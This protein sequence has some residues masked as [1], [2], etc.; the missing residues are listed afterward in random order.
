MKEIAPPLEA[1]SDP[2]NASPDVP[3]GGV[4]LQVMEPPVVPR[5]NERELPAVT[6]GG[7]AM[8]PV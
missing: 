3:A 4:A 2:L 1:P 8:V 5:T 7:V 6:V